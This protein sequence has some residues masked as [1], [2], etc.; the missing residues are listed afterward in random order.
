MFDWSFCCD[1][2]ICWFHVS[3]Y[4]PK[5][6][7]RELDCTLQKMDKDPNV[8][9]VYSTLTHRSLTVYVNKYIQGVQE[10]D[11]QRGVKKEVIKNQ[12][13]HIYGYPI[14]DG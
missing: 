12:N 8:S 4:A 14:V 5:S 1:L 6:F 2:Y 3:F 7:L 9:F 11:D 13:Y 10:V